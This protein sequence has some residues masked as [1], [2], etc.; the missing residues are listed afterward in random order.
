MLRVAILSFWHV[1]AKG[2]ANQIRSRQDC[3]IVAVWDEIAERGRTM[4]AEM[5]APFYENLQDLL[6]NPEVDAVVVNAPSKM[7]PEVMVAAA[8]A[9]KHIF[10]EK[11]L[12]IHTAE[13]DQIIE[14]VE[15][16]N[17]KLIVSLPR[18][19]EGRV[20]YAKNAVD[21]GLLGQVTLVRTRLAHDGSVP[22]EGA[23]NGWLVE[24]F[25]DKENCGG[26]ALID[27][28]CHPMYLAHYFLGLPE[29]VSAQFGYVTGHE[30]EDNAVVTL[31]YKDGAIAVVESGFTSRHSPF[32]VEIYGTEGCLLI[33]NQV[34]IRSNLL[35]VN[36]HTGWIRPD[37]LP[38]NLPS[39]IDQWVDYVL[40]D[41]TPVITTEQGRALTQLMEAAYL[42]VAE[43]RNVKL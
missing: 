23:P 10:T 33:G 20:L 11:V 9:G 30:V 38:A 24:H 41:K 27:L 15:Q 36:Q 4:A 21:Q 18:L 28:G 6:A 13:A 5:N 39:P 3:S 29:T 14:A 34:E 2:Y 31:G 19:C 12:A 8:K 37:R 7:H 17:V 42:S 16:N 43:G 22:R 40:Q 35:N 26:G 1:H 32:T 25:Y